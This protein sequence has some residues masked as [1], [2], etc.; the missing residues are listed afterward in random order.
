[1]S[2]DVTFPRPTLSDTLVA[3]NLDGTSSN[4]KYSGTLTA[5]PYTRSWSIHSIVTLDGRNTTKVEGERADVVIE[6]AS[7][8]MP[9]RIIGGVPTYQSVILRGSSSTPGRSPVT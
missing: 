6:Y 5:P 4:F 9:P 1:M 7:G 8:G 3:I 2:S